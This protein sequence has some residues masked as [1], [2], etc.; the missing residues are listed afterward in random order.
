MKRGIFS[1]ILA[2]LAGLSLSLVASC[3]GG[4]G[5]AGTAVSVGGGTTTV[6]I[7]SVRVTPETRQIAVSE[8]TTFTAQALDASGAVLSGNTF[9]FSSS[10][11]AVATVAGAAANPVSVK[12]VAEG[13]VTITATTGGKTGSA[14]LTVRGQPD[15]QV[16]GR[17]IDGQSQLGLAGAQLTLSS[18]SSAITASDGSFAFAVRPS[19]FSPGADSAVSLTATLAGYLSTTLL[20]GVSPPS[21]TLETILLVKPTGLAGSITGAVRNARNNQGIANA[22]VTLYQ[23][24]GASGSNLGSKTTDA[25]GGYSFTGLSAGV[26]TINA[27]PPDY[28]ACTR[29][30]ISLSSSA[31]ANQDISCSPFNSNE[32]RVVLTWG[33]SPGDLDAHLTGPN[34]TDATRFHIYYPSAS[35]GSVSINPFALLDVDDTSSFGPETITLTRLN[36]GVYRYSVHDF[37]NRNSATSTALGSSG[38]RVELY[39]PNNAL[40]DIFYVPNQRGTLWTVF[41]LVGSSSSVTVTPRNEMGLATEGSVIP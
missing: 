18:G 28:S 5:D 4:G 41:E 24:Q 35:R 3:G 15:I 6:T 39:R 20:A 21:T 34:A 1:S 38:A 32:F 31:S 30:A 19:E 17:V 36:S 8:T 33:S 29:T 23:G 27:F 22:T 11:P 25:Q 14:V 37:T 13:V 7:A 26:Y 16:S 12:G 10:N 2:G 9:T 40:P